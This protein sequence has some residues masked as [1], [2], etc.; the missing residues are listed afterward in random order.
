MRLLETCIAVSAECYQGHGDEDVEHVPLHCC[1]AQAVRWPTNVPTDNV[2][3]NDFLL[4]LLALSNDVAMRRGLVLLCDPSASGMV[5]VGYVGVLEGDGLGGDTHKHAIEVGVVIGDNH[6]HLVKG[7]TGFER[8]AFSPRIIE[9]FVVREALSWLK[10]W[11]LG[12]AI[13]MLDCMSVVHA[14][15][16]PIVDDSEF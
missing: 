7:L 3:W 2:T 5:G 11:H 16:Q 8:A 1:K 14:L 6:G 9:A 15:T 13:I 4:G 10:S 12:H